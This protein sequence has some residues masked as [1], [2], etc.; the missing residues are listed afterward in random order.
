MLEHVATRRP[1][2]PLAPKH[3][4]WIGLHF[5]IAVKLALPH[6]R[7][8]CS[9]LPRKMLVTLASS[10]LKESIGDDRHNKTA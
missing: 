5:R 9:P 8:A 7:E 6:S 1:H 2:A 3:A 4:I 10:C